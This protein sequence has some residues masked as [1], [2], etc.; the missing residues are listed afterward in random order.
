ME[1]FL[2]MGLSDEQMIH[3]EL[4]LV[5]DR[6]LKCLLLNHLKLEYLDFHY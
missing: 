5:P 2:G 3:L 4:F 6:S 1:V